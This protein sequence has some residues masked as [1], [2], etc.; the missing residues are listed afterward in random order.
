MDGADPEALRGRLQQVEAELAALRRTAAEVRLR[1][2]EH[3]FGPTDEEERAALITA[4]EE[5]EALAERLEIRRRELRRRLGE[6]GDSGA[7]P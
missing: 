2:G 4:A 1:I 7:G 5:Q 3:W 6:E